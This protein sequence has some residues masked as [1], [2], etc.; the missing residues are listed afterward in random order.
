M[1][2][3]CKNC[4]AELPDEANICLN[5]LEPCNEIT[6]LDGKIES[7]EEASRNRKK[8]IMGVISAVTVLCLIVP[9]FGSNNALF[10]KAKIKA[11]ETSAKHPSIIEEIAGDIINRNDD[12]E[13]PTEVVTVIDEN[14]NIEEITVVATESGIPGEAINSNGNAKSS[15][16]T[17]S[18]SNKNAKSNKGGTYSSSQNSNHSSSAGSLILFPS[19]TG[20]VNDKNNS[21]DKDKDESDTK[22]TDKSTSKTTTKP[23]TK[24]TTKATTAS[25][26][27]SEKNF[28][29][30]EDRGMVNITAYT[31]NEEN[32]VVPAQLGGKD[33]RYVNGFCQNNSKIKTV[34]FQKA[35]NN[36]NFSIGQYVFSDCPSLEKI[37]FPEN[38][39]LSVTYQFA[40]N[41][42]SLKTVIT[43][44]STVRCINGVVYGGSVSGTTFGGVEKN[45]E[46]KIGQILEGYEG[47]S[48]VLD[49][50]AAPMWG[51][52]YNT[53]VK[54]VR[55]TKK[56]DDRIYTVFMNNESVED[57][58]VDSDS[59][60]WADENGFLIN[61]VTRELVYY[62]P[63]KD[64]QIIT[65]PENSILDTSSLIRDKKATALKIPNSAKISDCKY[66]FF[67]KYPFGKI[68][69]VY[70]N[71]SHP[72]Y[73]E[74]KANFGGTIADYN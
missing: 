48:L 59:I 68:T 69:K 41:C 27:S 45:G 11:S 6:V 19:N 5:C 46:N 62:P 61:K 37:V 32:V 35:K 30:V 55:I 13:V 72:Q 47:S 22:T 63:K 70:V 44:S 38:V 74:I 3:I 57:V 71:K 23:T 54:K 52:E 1:A 12:G 60:N 14:G 58:E 40:K 53:H 39:N 4:G 18:G 21:S 31:G 36:H 51:L 20:D 28:A 10:S 43:N 7:P 2:K 49:G 26:V 33:I 9:V 66:T 15:A 29:Y 8:A 17:N 34:T 65:L 50:S 67:Y 16:N 56:A 25:A 64:S 42:P 73:E 24:A